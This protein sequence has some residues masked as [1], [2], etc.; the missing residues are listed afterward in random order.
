MEYVDDGDSEAEVLG[1]VQESHQ[2]LQDATSQSDQPADLPPSHH[3]S[4]GSYYTTV[5]Y[6]SYDDIVVQSASWTY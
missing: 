5:T 2:I 4:R 6:T 1:P 3:R